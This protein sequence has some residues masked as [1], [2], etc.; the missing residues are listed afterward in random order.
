VI[1]RDLLTRYRGTHVHVLPNP[2]NG[3]D[4]LIL[5]G[6]RRLCAEFDLSV[7]ELNY[8][9]PASGRLLLA[10][11]NGNLCVP[12]HSCVERV[13]AYAD[14]F[15]TLAILPC[16]VELASDAVRGFLTA[17]PSHAHVFC[18]EAYSFALVRELV[19]PGRNVWLDHDL[20]IEADLSAWRHAG[21][22]TLY[23][24]RVDPESTGEPPPPGNVD[25]SALTG[26]WMTELLLDVISTFASVHTDR[27]HVAIAAARLGRE[28]HI[29]PNR[30]HK[31]RGIYE[32]SLA[33]YDNA[34]FHEVRTALPPLEVDPRFVAW[35]ARSDAEAS[36][37]VRDAEGFG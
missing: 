31:V 1:V 14:R 8:P 21:R 9:Y 3:G 17:L 20:A 34:H 29:Y 18:R 16:S 23:A 2:G 25:V 6:L 5:R 19:G 15:D 12:Y 37:T 7:T 30:Y 35:R 22:G 11:G 36:R 24:F 27:A 33:R 32:Q 13:S 4:G 28:T 10:P 26:E